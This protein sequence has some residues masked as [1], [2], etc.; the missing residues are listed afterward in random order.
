MRERP[1][2]SRRALVKCKLKKI[3]RCTQVLTRLLPAPGLHYA[4]AKLLSIPRWDGLLSRWVATVSLTVEVRLLDR[5]I[6][7]RKDTSLHLV[8]RK[9]GGKLID[10]D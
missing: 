3:T 6:V 5:K 8:V 1:P 4:G 2:A 7:S 9:M 10:S